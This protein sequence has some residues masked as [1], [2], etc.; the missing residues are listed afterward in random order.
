MV[1]TCPS[2][3]RC[4]VCN[5]SVRVPLTNLENATAG[6]ILVDRF[7]RR[8]TSANRETLKRLIQ[9]SCPCPSCG[10]TVHFEHGRACFAQALASAGVPTHERESILSKITFP[11]A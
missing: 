11:E 8:E 10:S 5:T 9:G 3:A 6:A 1:C 4:S 7:A 2:P